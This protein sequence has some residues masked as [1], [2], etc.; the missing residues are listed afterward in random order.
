MGRAALPVALSTAL[1]GA[2]AFGLSRVVSLNVSP[3]APIGLYRPVHLPVERNQLVVGCVPP[4]VAALA[5]ERG[6]LGKGSCPGGVQPVLKRLVGLPG[7]VVEIGQDA[8]TVN[9]VPLPDSATASCDSLGRPLPHAR[10]GR[11]V[12]GAGE[13]WLLGTAARR[14]WDSRYFGAVSLDHVRAVSPVLILMPA[15]RGERR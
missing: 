4:R 3:S 14:S 5:W 6:Y 8:V 2:A 15:G 1:T 9:G 11:T 13:V 7:D 12:L 10:W